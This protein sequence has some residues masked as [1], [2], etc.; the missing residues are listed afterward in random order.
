MHTNYFHTYFG[1]TTVTTDYRK[2][3]HYVSLFYF[4]HQKNTIKLCSFKSTYNKIDS[5]YKIYPVIVN[6]ESI[7]LLLIN[8]NYH[9]VKHCT[10]VCCV[11]PIVEEWKTEGNWFLHSFK[12]P[13][14]FN[15]I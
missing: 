3:V 2:Q 15:L 9:E 5:I 14:M 4:I 13:Q 8:A 7:A 12:T 6:P 1:P 10:T 11:S